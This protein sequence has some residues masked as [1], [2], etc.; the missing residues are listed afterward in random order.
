MKRVLHTPKD[1]DEI[2]QRFR[3]YVEEWR[4]R[5]VLR[6]WSINLHLGLE[7]DS[8]GGTTICYPKY[9]EADIM[10]RL[11]EG[12]EACWTDEETE[13]AA[14]HELMHVLVSTWDVIWQK[15]HKKPLGAPMMNMLLISEEQLCTR[16]ALGFM[17]TKYPHRK[18]HKLTD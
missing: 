8:S 17:R 14:I 6:E 4:I 12:L 3:A 9:N 15:T 7:G 16:L 5:L 11:P 2:Y 1:R 10:L 13:E 18:A